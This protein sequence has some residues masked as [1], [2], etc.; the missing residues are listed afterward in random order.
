MTKN[1]STSNAAIP[2]RWRYCRT[3][4]YEADFLTVN[5]MVTATVLKSW[6][7]NDWQV[8]IK[9]VERETGCATSLKMIASSIPTM[10]EAKVEAANYIQQRFVASRTA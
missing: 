7:P 1:T 6:L 8:L 10:R 2:L 3:S 5:D 4:V 9:V